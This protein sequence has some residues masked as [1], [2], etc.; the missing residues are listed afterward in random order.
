MRLRFSRD[1]RLP[2]PEWLVLRTARPSVLITG[3]A[4]T[5]EATLAALMPHMRSPV[6]CW[7]PD[8]SLPSDGDVTTRPDSQRRD[9]VGRPAARVGVVVGPCAPK[10]S[11]TR[12]D[13]RHPVVSSCRRWA[14]SR[15]AVLPFEH[16]PPRHDRSLRVIAPQ[17]TTACTVRILR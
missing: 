16:R 17:R 15:C 9:T 2:T 7:T 14:V 1:G 10:P 3:T 11:S 8:A 6:Y 12:V 5:I 4:D 13:E